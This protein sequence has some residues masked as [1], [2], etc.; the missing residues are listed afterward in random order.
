MGILL[1]PLKPTGYFRLA[2]EVLNDSGVSEGRGVAER[3]KLILGY[4]AQDAAHDFAGT[5]LRQAWRR[6]AMRSGV[7]I[8]PIS[9]RT[10]D[11]ELFVQLRGRWFARHQRHIGVD[12]LAL[13]VVPVA[14]R[15]AASDTFGCPRL[16][17]RPKG[18]HRQCRDRTSLRLRLRT[19]WSILLTTPGIFVAVAIGTFRT[20]ARL[21]RMF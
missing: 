3:A 8:G 2:D 6:I 21:R 12:A 18:S 15:I 16:W 9:L 7:A 1:A 11:H 13:D 19:S 17:A 4:L 5:R 14:D 20:V 10:P